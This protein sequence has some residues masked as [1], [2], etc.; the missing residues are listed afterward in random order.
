MAA[1]K[2]PAE[3]Q[4]ET[5]QYELNSTKAMKKK[6]SAANESHF[7]ITETGGS[8]TLNFSAGSYEIFRFATDKFYLRKS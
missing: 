3:V 8:I 4:S 5:N 2:D 7:T 6:L 1:A